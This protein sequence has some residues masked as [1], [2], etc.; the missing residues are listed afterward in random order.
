MPGPSSSQALPKIIQLRLRAKI[1]LKF[2]FIPKG[3]TTTSFEMPHQF[4]GIIAVG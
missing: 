1:P 4:H 2:E 3:R